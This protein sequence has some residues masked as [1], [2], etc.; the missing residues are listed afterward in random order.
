MSSVNNLSARSSSASNN[1][2]NSN[3]S[4][5]AAAQA[6]PSQ[7]SIHHHHHFN[8]GPP[9]AP[10]AAKSARPAS[11]IFF[12]NAQ[13]PLPEARH[14]DR[15]FES[16]TQ[17]EDMLEDMAKVS[18]D[19]VFKDELNAIDQ[20][21][22]VLSEPE[23][24]AAL[25][26]LMQHCS[27]LQVRFFITILQQMLKMDQDPSAHDA[28]S[29]A[30][31]NAAAVDHRHSIA[32]QGA[33][34][35]AGYSRHI[36]APGPVHMSYD[37]NVSLAPG[38]SAAGSLQQQR[39]GGWGVG[40]GLLA[41]VAGADG[42]RPAA[43]FVERPKSSNHEADVNPDWRGNRVGSAVASPTAEHF[44]IH[45]HQQQVIG[46]G[47]AVR[48]QSGNVLGQHQTPRASVDM[49]PKDFR[50]S[51]LTDSLEPFGNIGP[52]PNASALTHILETNMNRTSGI[53]ARRSVSNR[54]SIA[55]KSPRETMQGNQQQQLAATLAQMTM[56]AA[57]PLGTSSGYAHHH[58]LQHHQE[59]QQ[60][61]LHNPQLKP[62]PFQPRAPYQQ[63]AS[64]VGSIGSPSHLHGYN[65]VRVVQQPIAPQQMHQPLMGHASPTPGRG[66]FSRP[67][68]GTAGSTAGSNLSVPSS[69][70]SMKPQEPVDLSLVRDIPAWLRSLR[71]HKY[72]ECFADMDWTDVVGLS[73]EDLQAKGVIALGARRKMLKVFEAVQDILERDGDLDK[74][75]IAL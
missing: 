40:D 70:A 20:W 1:S 49:E 74:V 34:L 46:G 21:F 50:W 73:D 12:A 9:K 19:P 54:L 17:F 41:S 64:A 6:L 52:D 43:A 28:D 25:Y 47:S 2:S 63:P 11:E 39:S 24:T 68:A 23:R 18:L 8:P 66:T 60:Q 29:T 7:D 62:T 36:Q 37:S 38:S 16:L 14:V 45:H 31:T 44:A 32:A 69:P 58:Q 51:S 33:P 53:A 55:V 71:L 27:D 56:N 75:G 3:N 4:V 22:S 35:N 15:W 30:A 61:Y 72:T 59:P 13:H 10:F 5:S 48:R 65:G 42:R 67:S 26:S 57:S